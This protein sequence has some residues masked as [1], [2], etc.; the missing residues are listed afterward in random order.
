[1]PTLAP[2]MPTA[3]LTNMVAGAFDVEQAALLKI[4]YW[5]QTA[6]ETL[7]GTNSYSMLLPSMS[8]NANDSR[9][10]LLVKAAYWAEQIADN[11]GGGGGGGLAFST[12]TGSPEGAVTG[13]PGDTYWDTAT[14]FKYTKVTGIATNTGWFV[15]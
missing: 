15:H 14:D 3:P 10:A 1:M 9:Q 2:F 4:V 13:S 11:A 7:G 12:G 5:L 8:A 6:A